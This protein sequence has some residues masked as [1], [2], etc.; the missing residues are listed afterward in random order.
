MNQLRGSKKKGKMGTLFRT[1][2]G[3]GSWSNGREAK[4]SKIF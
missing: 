4:K 3:K 1:I 2:E